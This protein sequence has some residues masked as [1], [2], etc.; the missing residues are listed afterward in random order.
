MVTAPFANRLQ[1]IEVSVNMSDCDISISSSLRTERRSTPDILTSGT[2]RRFLRSLFDVIEHEK[3]SLQCPE[4]G[5]DELRYIIYR[6]A[7][8]KVIARSAAY[9]RLLLTIKAEYDDSI[10]EMKRRQEARNTQGT[11]ATLRSH[12]EPLETCR[13][14]AAQ[15][16]LR[17]SALHRET[18]EHEEQIQRCVSSRER[19]TW[20]PG[21]TVAECEDAE[22]LDV[23]LELL[24]AQRQALL[25]RKRHCVPQEVKAVLDAKLQAAEKHREQLGSENHCLMALYQRLRFVCDRLSS[26]EEE[27]QQVPLEEL[28]GSTLQNMSPAS[29]KGDNERGSTAGLFED[30]EPSG[31]DGLRLLS[32]YLHRFSELFDSAQFEDA[33]LLA[34]RSPQGVLRNLDT[35]EM[36][37]GVEGSLG[38]PPPL[39]YFS[40]ALLINTPAGTELAAPLSVQVVRCALQ[41]D[42]SELVS[43][44]VTHS[45]L[46]FSEDLGDIL[47][48]HAQ[49]NPTVDDLFL[50]LATTVYEAC[51]LHRKSALSMCTRGLIHSAAEFLNHCKDLTVEDCLWIVRRSP[52]L[53]L[54]QLLTRPEQG[55]AAMLS[56]GDVC[57]S[58]LRDAQLQNLGLQ[59]LDSFFS[60]EVLEEVMLKDCRSS[61]DVWTD[62]SFLCS[63]LKR[64]DLSQG[65]LSILLDQSGTGVRCPDLEGAQLMEHVFL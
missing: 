49:K 27:G 33:A 61:V 23:H 45:K 52:S 17:I 54:V 26:W 29:V 15:L 20:I 4:H 28:L 56:A 32:D 16:S 3:R 43:H 64:P 65:I 21:L 7:F 14:R 62:V 63:G 1:Q 2:D 22:A 19:S 58:L 57:S 55:R 31:G 36:F 41:C 12:P 30:E 42:A 47:T 24:Q 18:A 50:A 53:A 59:L 11:L 25:D 34:A 37:R 6:S 35:M 10:R 5:P 9:A 46:T 51:G 48:E 39:L 40:Q 38:S 13:R 8:N 44:A 60:K